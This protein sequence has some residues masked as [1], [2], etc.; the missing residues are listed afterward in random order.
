MK[1][2]NH[3]TPEESKS[4]FTYKTRAG[5]AMKDEYILLYKNQKIV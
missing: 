5:K 3:K 2:R 4:R 1:I